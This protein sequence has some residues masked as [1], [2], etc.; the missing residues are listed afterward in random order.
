[1]VRVAEGG[2]ILQRVELERTERHSRWCSAARA[3]GLFICTA[4]WH[5]ANLERLTTGPRTGQIIA[6]TVEPGGGRP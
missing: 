3:G 5:L 6:L 4:K 2:E 1:M